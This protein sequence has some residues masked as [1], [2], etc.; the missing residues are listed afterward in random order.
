MTDKEKR[1][2]VGTIRTLMSLA[3][4]VH[5]VMDSVDADNC[6]RIIKLINS[7]PKPKKGRW[8]NNRSDIGPWFICSECGDEVYETGNYCTTCGSY[9]GGEET[10]D[11]S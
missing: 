4:N 3:Y 8:L 11:Q 7:Q 10:G 6:E 9:N 2:C 5:G 1:S